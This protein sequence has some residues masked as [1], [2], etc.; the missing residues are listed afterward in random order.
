MS[1]LYSEDAGAIPVRG[2]RFGDVAQMV[3]HL[4]LNQ[5]VLGSSPSIPTN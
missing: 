3:E 2:S 1:D 4:T 5:V